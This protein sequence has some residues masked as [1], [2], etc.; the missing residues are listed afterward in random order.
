MAVIQASS[1][2]NDLPTGFFLLAAATLTFSN[3]R[4]LPRGVHGGLVGAALGLA[5][6]TKGTA[7]LYGAPLGIVLAVLTIRKTGR[8]AVAPLFAA[9]IVAASLNAGHWWRNA[10][11]FGSPLVAGETTVPSGVL[12]PRS[13]GSNVLRVVA[14][15]LAT[16]SR[17]ANA[18]IVLGVTVA[19]KVIGISPSLPATTFAGA[20]FGLSAS[21][22]YE[23]RGPLPIAPAPGR[24]RNDRRCGACA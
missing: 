12:G 20:R 17:G 16:P 10:S 19:R 7:Y 13:F 6:L 5:L 1:T 18:L 21:V 2:L 4:L 24:G 9:G 23:G 3:Q 15:D 8:R 22:F 14:L 11:V